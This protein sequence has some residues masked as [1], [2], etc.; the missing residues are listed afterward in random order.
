MK[1]VRYPGVSALAGLLVALGVVLAGCGAPAYTYVANIQ[2]HAYFKVPSGWS[3]IKSAALVKALTGSSQSAGWN[4]GFDAS[5]KPAAAHVLSSVPASPFVYARAT[6][7]NQSTSDA[8][9]YNLLKNSFLPVTS[10]ARSTATQDGF[11]LTAFQLL[12]SATITAGGGVHGVREIYDYTYPSGLVVTFDQES[13]TN[14]DDTSVY[15]LLVHCT[16]ACYLH[17]QSA[18][19]TVMDSFTVRSS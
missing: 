19:N 13:L 4:V 1:S 8:L 7:V 15:T 11:P 5:A 18:I 17:N 2:Q 3:S 12:S 14:A 10:D 16:Q 9:S 6:P